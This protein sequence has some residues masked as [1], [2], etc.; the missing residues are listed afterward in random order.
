M[1]PLID[2]LREQLTRRF[3]SRTRAVSARG[4]QLELD[5]LS[6]EEA[7]RL[8]RAE[9]FWEGAATLLRSGLVYLIEVVPSVPAAMRSLTEESH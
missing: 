7:Y 8:G 5:G 1:M 9:G 3:V 6:V 4:Q 2:T